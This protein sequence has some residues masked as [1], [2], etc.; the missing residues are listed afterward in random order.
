MAT[1]A[2][3]RRGAGP[4]LH[5]LAFGAGAALLLLWA[6]W[7]ALGDART[8]G[9]PNDDIRRYFAP[10]YAFVR[11]ALLDGRL[12]LWNP[13]VFTGQPELASGQSGVLYPPQLAVLPALGVTA[14]IEL[15]LLLHLWLLA[16]AGYAL[17]TRWLQ[18]R[19]E[20]APIGAALAG[21]GV[22]LS[23]FSMGRLAGGHLSLLHALPWLVLVLAAG[24]G[25]VARASRGSGAAMAVSMALAITAGGMQLAPLFAPVAIFL[26]TTVPLARGAV[27]RVAGWG[28]IGLALAGAQ[29]VPSLE[30]AAHAA[31]AHQPLEGIAE[32]FSLRWEH[33]P[34][35]LLPHWVRT[36]QPHGF[37]ELDGFV[38]APIVALAVMPAL[39]GPHRGAAR[40]LWAGVLL[41]VLLASAPLA[42]VLGNLPGFHLLR[43]PARLLVGPAIILPLLAALGLALVARGGSARTTA[44]AALTTVMALVVA[45]GAWVETRLAVPTLLAA[46]VAAAALALRRLPPMAAVVVAALCAAA[47]LIASA[48]D[49]LRG[50]PVEELGAPRPTSLVPGAGRR[51]VGEGGW[52]LGMVE[53]WRNLGGYEPALT[54]RAALL[55]RALDTGDPAGAWTDLGLLWPVRAPSRPDLGLRFGLSPEDV[56]PSAES[57]ATARMAPTRVALA[58]CAVSVPGTEEALAAALELPRHVIAVEGE[59]LPCAGDSSGDVGPTLGPVRVLVDD[60]E[61]IVVEAVVPQAALLVVPDLPF[62]G[63]EARVDDLSA[64]ILP[65]DGAGRAILLS[66]GEHRVELRYRP[67]SL[68]VG[69][70]LS[71]GGLVALLVAWLLPSG[72]AA[73]R[74]LATR[75]H[76]T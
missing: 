37:W 3:A 43:V 40:V 63:W 16:M 62:P 66:A 27:R 12:P 75:S 74:R 48:E 67:L 19:G 68:R 47:P 15:G 52:N 49:P 21:L 9:G 45:L 69:A 1:R 39:V 11:D 41:L 71:A 22:A 65:A 6:G 73:A 20:S 25:V 10:H 24:I 46:A 23:G 35:L 59:G 70:A 42:P 33:L 26:W 36:V 32:L 4:A 76:R 60:P 17:T 29:A 28:L 44:A 30:L 18:A 64:P 2:S 54:W 72:V 51:L 8:Y 55:V 61:R 56:L 13:H 5:V 58:R 7:G 57:P 34:G 14:W 31:R 50:S 53:G 38:G